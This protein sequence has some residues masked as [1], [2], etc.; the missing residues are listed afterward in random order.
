MRKN[1]IGVILF[2]AAI[3][4]LVLLFVIPTKEGF[5]ETLYGAKKNKPSGSK[6]DF[7][8]ECA[9]NFCRPFDTPEGKRFTCV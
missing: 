3:A 5:E 9:S 8:P 6:C 4:V 1:T 2:F 7:D